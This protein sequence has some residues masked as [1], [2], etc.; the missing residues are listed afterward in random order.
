MLDADGKILL[1][2]AK[3]KLGANISYLHIRLAR[4]IRRLVPK[5]D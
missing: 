4:V 3:Q 1:G 5:K 2:P